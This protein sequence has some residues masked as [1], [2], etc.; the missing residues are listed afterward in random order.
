MTSSSS[1]EE[2]RVLRRVLVALVGVWNSCLGTLLAT[3]AL[4]SARYDNSVPRVPFENKVVS[5]SYRPGRSEYTL[6]EWNPS[7]VRCRTFKQF[8]TRERRRDW[9]SYTSQYRFPRSLTCIS[10]LSII[11]SA[12]VK[13]T[14]GTKFRGM[15]FISS[16]YLTICALFCRTILALS[17]E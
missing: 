1:M 15:G 7:R 14:G 17:P 8:S 13:L 5:M 16:T 10:P 9:K 6:R 12:I 4:S 2:G 11:R 3:R